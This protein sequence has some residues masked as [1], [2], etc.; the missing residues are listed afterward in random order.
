M[1]RRSERGVSL[2]ESVIAI[3]ILGIASAALLGGITTGT[4]GSNL[5]RQQADD[6]AVLVSAGEAV[7]DNSLTPYT[8]CA[9][10][11][12]PN[13]S[14]YTWP[15][16]SGFAWSSSNVVVTSITYWNGSGWQ[17]TCTD[18]GNYIDTL[19]LITVTVTHPNGLVKVSRDFVKAP[20]S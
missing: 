8:H 14:G 4:S 6:D 9:T 12:V 3:A 11:Y 7:V 13:L 17:A 15:N 1:A 18:D 10:S 5:H 16:T 20:S 19:Q 2:L